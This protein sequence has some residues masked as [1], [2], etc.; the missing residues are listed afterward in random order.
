[1]NAASLPVYKEKMYRGRR[2]TSVNSSDYG[3]PDLRRKRFSQGGVARPG[4]PRR[5]TEVSSRRGIGQHRSPV[6][7]RSHA[8]APVEASVHHREARGS[9]DSLENR[10]GS[11][12]QN[13]PP[14]RYRGTR[15]VPRLLLIARPPAGNASPQ[16]SKGGG[17]RR[18][19]EGPPPGGGT[20]ATRTVLRVVSAAAR[21]RTP[22][23]SASDRPEPTR[24]AVTAFGRLTTWREATEAV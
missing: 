23:N 7:A 2:S 1:M 15:Y 21:G 6:L 4:N 17:S 16:L 5:D 9:E 8:R 3:I 19:A 24:I 13:R 20:S 14:R 10:I 18:V 12:A 22:Q 11:D